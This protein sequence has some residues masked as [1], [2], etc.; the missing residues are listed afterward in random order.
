LQ[1]LRLTSVIL[2]SSLCRF[3]YASPLQ[4]ESSR[5]LQINSPLSGLLEDTPV[6]YSVTLNAGDFVRLI[7][8][9]RD[10]ALDVS[11]LHSDN[12]T[13]VEVKSSNLSPT[14]IAAVADRSGLYYISVSSL[15][16]DHLSVPYSITLAALTPLTPRSRDQLLAVTSYQAATANLSLWR[17][18]AL[19]RAIRDLGRASYYWQLSGQPAEAARVLF[20]AGKTY[21]S[22]SS[23]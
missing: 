23:F 20:R 3:G 14:E 17:R 12:T 19:V 4:H 22:L 6:V 2:A 18:A 13:L 1:L 15:E 16:S 11:M 8:N 5:Q 9:H 21:E 7:I 10:L